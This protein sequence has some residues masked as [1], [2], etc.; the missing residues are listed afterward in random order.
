MS[1]R[2]LLLEDDTLFG[3][4]LMDLLEEEAFE[5]VH[6]TNGQDAL[7]ATYEKKFDLYLLDIN[8]PIVKGTT[9]LSELR[10][11]KDTTPAIFL[12]SHKD[13]SMLEEGF[14]SGCD[15]YLTKPFDTSELLLRIQALL[16]RTQK[17]RPEVVGKLEHD[18]LHKSIKYDGNYLELSKKEYELL[19][20]FM[21]H[22][23]SVVPKELIYDELWSSAQSGS[24]G[25]IRVYINRLK[26]LLPQVSIENV[27]GIGY[28][29]V[30]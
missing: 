28:K 15:D 11:A 22:A 14:L 3:E 30:S 17:N 7:N 4:T 27:R 29:L 9:L 26:Q 12:T 10:N 23:N 19:L 1:S 18:A 16:R 6:I 20:L 21:K 8:V 24:D 13:K 5:V 2:I 25:A